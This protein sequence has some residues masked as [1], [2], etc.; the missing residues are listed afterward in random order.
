LDMVRASDLLD[1]R[2]AYALPVSLVN[3]LSPGQTTYLAGP[4]PRRISHP[5]PPIGASDPA[6]DNGARATSAVVDWS[7]QPGKMPTGSHRA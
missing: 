2:A 5:S 4:A 6:G 1:R 3:A 7:Q